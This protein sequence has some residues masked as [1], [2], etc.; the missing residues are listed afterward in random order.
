[1]FA[2]VYRLERP[3]IYLDINDISDLHRVENDANGLILG[4]NVTLSVVK[5]TFKKLSK[6]NGFQH[7]QFMANHVDLIASV[8]VRNVS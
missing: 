5:T 1:M 2:G 6:N 4:G 8:A 3:Q 7:L